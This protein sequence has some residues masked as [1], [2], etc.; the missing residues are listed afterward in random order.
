ML[1]RRQSE[2]TLALNVTHVIHVAMISSAVRMNVPFASFRL[3]QAVLTPTR[4]TIFGPHNYA[5][6]EAMCLL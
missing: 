2:G 4:M 3:M 1:V 5:L 6:S